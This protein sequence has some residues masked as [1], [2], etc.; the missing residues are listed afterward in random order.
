MVNKNVPVSKIIYCFE[1][2]TAKGWNHDSKTN[3]TDYVLRD[4]QVTCN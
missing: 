3:E 2:T 1:F 4:S